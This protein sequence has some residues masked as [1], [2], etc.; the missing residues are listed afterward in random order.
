MKEKTLEELAYLIKNTK[1]QN[2]PKPIVFI[3]AGMSIS[4]GIPTATEISK[5]IL[6]KYSDHP[7]IKKLSEEDKNY[8]KIMGCLPPPERKKILKEYVNK[9]KINVSHIY[10]AHILNLGYVD[11]ILTTNFDNLTQRALA[12]YNQ[13]PPTYDISILKDLTTTSLEKKSIVYLHGKYD[14]LWQLNTTE[15]LKKIE[16]IIPPLFHKITSN[17]SWIVIGYSGND[18]IFEHLIELGRFD[19]GLY[20]IG[21]QDEEPSDRVKNK[22]LNRPNTE[23]YYISGYDADSFFLKLNTELGNTEPSIFNTPF[24]FLNELQE[25]IIDINDNNEYKGVK[26]RLDSAKKMVRDA[27]KR[28]EIGV[29][30]S[31]ELNQ[32]EIRKFILQKKLVNSLI[33]EEYHN[34]NEIE[35]E[36]EENE[37][38]DFKSIFYGIYNNWGLSL[39]NEAEDESSEKAKALYNQAFQKF[40]KAVTINSNLFVAWNNWGTTLGSY[41]HRFEKENEELYKEVFDKFKKATTRNP[42]IYS[43]WVDWGNYLNLYAELKAKKESDKFIKEAFEKFHKAVEI[44]P[45][46]HLAWYNWGKALG[47]LAHSKTGKEAEEYYLDAIDKLE[48]VIEIKPDLYFGWDLLGLANMQLA[49]IK[50]GNYAKNYYKSAIS[51]FKKTLSLNPNSSFAMGNMGKCLFELSKLEGVDNPKEL[52]EKALFYIEESIK[53]DRSV[54]KYIVNDSDWELIYNDKEIK[55]LISKYQ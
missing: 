29:D 52:K 5:E 34:V 49:N 37:K 20:W 23:S 14:G 1:E 9:A 15:E 44:N 21:Y 32:D 30:S 48:K 51:A 13:F 2:D 42:N 4:A 41:L 33:K 31:E 45:N 11:F 40:K 53:I 35:E 25:S 50:T 39:A 54:I 55:K 24:S 43:A 7:S 47:T 46:N 16:K 3:G 28:Y 19:N 18:P 27:I 17:R 38:E 36:L 22:L 26:E 6:I 10:L 12:L 8:Y